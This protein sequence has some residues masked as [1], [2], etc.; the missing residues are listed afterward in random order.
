MANIAKKVEVGANIAIIIAVVIIGVSFVRNHT[1]KQQPASHQIPI[2][3]KFTLQN[4]NW[5]TNEKNLVFALSTNC[6]FCSESADFYRQIAQ[7]KAK[8][9]RTIAVFPQPVEAAQ[10]YTKK[11]G[12]EF[13]EVRQASLTGLEINGTPTLLIIDNGGLVRNVWVGKLPTQKEKEVLAKVGS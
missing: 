1:G 5:K 9:V 8:N 7:A 4:V 2:G 13:D 10:E 12:I 11:M 6:H 3:T